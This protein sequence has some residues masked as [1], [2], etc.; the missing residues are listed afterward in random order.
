[1]LAACSHYTTRRGSSEGCGS[2]P[3][4]LLNKKSLLT[5]PV[6]AFPVFFMLLPFHTPVV[7]QYHFFVSPSFSQLSELLSPELRT[8]TQGCSATSARQSIAQK[9]TLSQ[10]W[11]EYLSI[12]SLVIPEAEEHRPCCRSVLVNSGNLSNMCMLQ[13]QDEEWKSSAVFCCFS[14]LCQPMTRSI[15][16]IAVLQPGHACEMMN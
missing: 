4:L 15:S 14:V 1:M 7:P 2:S 10:N 12:V 11:T 5:P 13:A 8:A 9:D 16:F 3:G 6:F